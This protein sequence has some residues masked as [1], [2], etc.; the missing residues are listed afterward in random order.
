VISSTWHTFVTP[1]EVDCALPIKLEKSRRNL[2]HM[3]EALPGFELYRKLDVIS[4]YRYRRSDLAC[5][6]HWI[7]VL[8]KEIIQ[9]ERRKEMEDMT[10][11]LAAWVE[12]VTLMTTDLRILL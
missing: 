4:P 11:K 8:R 1:R 7:A 2:K 10:Q 6:R 3:S 5:H 12:G 9:R